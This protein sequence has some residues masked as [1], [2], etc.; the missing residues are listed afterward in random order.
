M[1]SV[2]RNLSHAAACTRYF[3]MYKTLITSLFVI[4]MATFSYWA[5]DRGTHTISDI[6]TT[7]RRPEVLLSWIHVLRPDVNNARKCVFRLRFF[8]VSAD[9]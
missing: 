6:D 9:R 8:G 1:N 2:H 7:A 5:T 4:V 3:Y